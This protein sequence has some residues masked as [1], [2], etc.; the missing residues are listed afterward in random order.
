MYTSIKTVR[1]TFFNQIVFLYSIGADIIYISTIVAAL[2]S[3]PDEAQI[4]SW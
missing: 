3:I 1:A 2:A 4:N